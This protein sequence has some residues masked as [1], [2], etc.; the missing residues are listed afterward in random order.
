MAEYIHLETKRYPLSEQDIRREMPN[1][2]FPVPFPCPDGYAVVFPV[3][4]P[5]HD[6]VIRFARLVA[7]QETDGKWYQAW[8]VVPRF[9]EYTDEQGVVHTVAEQEAAA[10]AADKAAKNKALVDGIV[11]QTQSRLDDFARTRN[12]DGILSLCT[13]ATSPTLKFQTEGQ[14]GVEARDATWAKLYEILAEV[15]V[16]TRPVPSGY[17]DIEPDLPPLAWPN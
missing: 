14:Y 13:Y 5:E 10:L 2:S 11:A 3:P 4:A 17:Q 9:T 16:G 8:E 15:E 6:T 7:P 12:Y 1:T